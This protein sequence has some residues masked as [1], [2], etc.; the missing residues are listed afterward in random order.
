MKPT[1][2]DLAWANQFKPDGINLETQGYNNL[3]FSRAGKYDQAHKGTYGNTQTRELLSVLN[4]AQLGFKPQISAGYANI[5][6]SDGKGGEHTRPGV[7]DIGLSGRN[8]KEAQKIKDILATRGVDYLEEGT[9][10][11]NWHLHVRAGGQNRP[12]TQAQRDARWK[13][14][15]QANASR[16][17]KLE[18][19]V[20]A[21][22][23]HTYQAPIPETI[24]PQGPTAEDLEWAKTVKPK[25]P[26][27]MQGVGNLVKVGGQMLQQIPGAFQKEFESYKSQ[28]PALNQMELQ[29]S[30]LIGALS[31]PTD[32]VN[33]ATQSWAPV[34][35]AWLGRDKYKPLLPEIYG[36]RDIPG[37]KQV[38]ERHPVGDFVGGAAIPVEGVLGAL[39]KGRLAKAAK[40]AGEV[41]APKSGKLSELPTPARYLDDG[42]AKPQTEADLITN[43]RKMQDAQKLEIQ[44]REVQELLDEPSQID[45]AATGVPRYGFVGQD[46]QLKVKPSEPSPAT[47]DPSMAESPTKTRELSEAFA[48]RQRPTNPNQIIDPRV[49]EI[50]E[51][52]SLLNAQGELINKPVQSIQRGSALPE[53][54]NLG[55][56]YN[57]ITGQK[58]RD[59]DT[60]SAQE[61]ADVFKT[62]IQDTKTAE[63]L[64]VEALKDLQSKVTNM[65]TLAGVDDISEAQR[66]IGR[67]INELESK[68][69]L[70]PEEGASLLTSRSALDDLLKAQKTFDDAD[71][72]LNETTARTPR[73]SIEAQPAPQRGLPN[74]REL[75]MQRAE[76]IAS[77]RNL[78]TP[79]R[80]REIDSTLPLEG[81]SV[82]V[83]PS[84]LPDAP[85]GSGILDSTGQPIQKAGQIRELEIPGQPKPSNAPLELPR[86]FENNVRELPT[87]A[88]R[89]D[90]P[91]IQP[92][93]NV[94]RTPEGG[95]VYT[96]GRDVADIQ[97]QL[98]GVQGQ[99]AAI[100]DIERHL[101][102]HNPDAVPAIRNILNAG[103]N[104]EAVKFSYIAREAPGESARVRDNFIP[105]HFT[106]ET[107]KPATQRTYL[108][109][110]F[111]SDDAVIS[112]LKQEIM[113]KG[114]SIDAAMLQTKGGGAIKPATQ[115]SRLINALDN[116]T[117]GAYLKSPRVHGINLG[118]TTR[119][120]AGDR[121]IR[122]D[123]IQE[124]SLTGRKVTPDQLNGLAYENKIAPTLQALSELANSGTSPVFKRAV[125]Q[126]QKGEI[127][128][129]TMRQLKAALKDEKLAAQF[130]NVLGVKA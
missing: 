101:Q 97:R 20:P 52:Q 13:Q 130:C 105:T 120:A 12:S 122:L 102:T 93:G 35:N 98:E 108:R 10:T 94:F 71:S 80:T 91:S 3:W 66:V 99:I 9:G 16:T 27:F 40:V 86:P 72:L 104:S 107:I 81:R 8:T 50:P 57:P 118:E 67:R 126:I 128:Q 36:V 41:E 18:L 25:D 48:E 49:R 15:Q 26:D 60:K 125:N 75:A 37:L 44:K 6:H 64:R 114:G 69:N 24:K 111:G 85:Q 4:D 28:N 89:V 7:F 96:H 65:R 115:V 30:A 53:G 116:L 29:G 5:G 127:T 19:P 38:T 82:D 117:D 68:A 95:E 77:T 14:A 123:T 84:R 2:E 103:K 58:Y 45:P 43:I 92:A 34:A 83:A 21:V 56:E 23:R 73:A 42:M 88:Q 119:S 32:L 113:D 62:D 106:Y 124:S 61:S 121:G 129:K 78:K 17:K 70:T 63:T 79:K 110:K 47:L 54:R 11:G 74:T 22:P 33:L 109:N 112:H 100:T 1:A 39:S 59:I 76:D 87:A 90:T 46:G 31:S 51:S 55:N